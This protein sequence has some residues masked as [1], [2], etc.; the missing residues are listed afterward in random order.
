MTCGFNGVFKRHSWIY[1][2]FEPSEFLVMSWSEVIRAIWI[3]FGDDL[4]LLKVLLSFEDHMVSIEHNQV[5]DVT[6]H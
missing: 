6:E 2:D 1:L 4:E 5:F 3:P